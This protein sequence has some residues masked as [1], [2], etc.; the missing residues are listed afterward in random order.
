M[1][2][3]FVLFIV[4]LSCFPALASEPGEPLD[5]SDWVIH[6]YRIGMTIDEARTI[7]PIKR[8]RDG[9]TVKEKGR[10]NGTLIF[11]EKGLQQYYAEFV[12]G[13]GGKGVVVARDLADRLHQTL[14]APDDIVVVKRQHWW[15][16]NVTPTHRRVPYWRDDRCDTLVSVEPCSSWGLVLDGDSRPKCFWCGSNSVHPRMEIQRL[17]TWQAYSDALPLPS[18][19]TIPLQRSLKPHEVDLQELPACEGQIVNRSGE[20]YW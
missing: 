1:K 17:S 10:F 12:S 19:D 18:A 2:Q 13:V 4:A 14:G 8:V 11:D 3:L 9:W 16:R 6:G 20:P 7:R 5:C 15:S